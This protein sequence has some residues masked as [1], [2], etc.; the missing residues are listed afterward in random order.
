MEFIK[1]NNRCVFESRL[2]EIH[3]VITAS[4]LWINTAIFHIAAH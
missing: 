4:L 3:F 1:P 2:A